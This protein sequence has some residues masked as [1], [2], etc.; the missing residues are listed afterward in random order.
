VGATKA[1]ERILSFEKET[2]L[3]RVELTIPGPGHVF[4]VGQFDT[5][6]ELRLLGGTSIIMPGPLVHARLTGGQ[7]EGSVGANKQTMRILDNLTV[8]HMFS[9]TTDGTFSFWLL[10]IGGQSDDLVAVLNRTLS[11]MYFADQP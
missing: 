6:T 11:A 10:G 4:V 3:L 2:V 9:L 5:K 7:L 1:T 8:S